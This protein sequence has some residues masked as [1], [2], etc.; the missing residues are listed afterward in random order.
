M[1]RFKILAS[2]MPLIVAGLLARADFAP[3]PSP[4]L[5]TGTVTLQIAAAPWQVQTSV[6]FTD[7]PAQATVRVQI[8]DNAEA[9]DFAV[10]DDVTDVPEAGQC[11]GIPRFV[12]I[13]ASA[14]DGAPRI[15]LSRDGGADFRI[16]V[17]SRSFTPREAA[18]LIVSAGR[19]HVVAASL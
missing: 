15:Y 1:S 10:I 13:L 3:T 5:T 14:T 8:I 7:D 11:G 6:S 2:T 16:H 17:S 18:A 12:G 19:P 9:A 4:C